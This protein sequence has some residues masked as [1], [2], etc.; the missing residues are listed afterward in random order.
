MGG[1]ALFQRS[2]GEDC[3][4][5]KFKILHQDFE[6]REFPRLRH[7]G[8]CGHWSKWRWRWFGRKRRRL[9]TLRRQRQTGR[10][11]ST[12]G[13]N[14]DR[15]NEECTACDKSGLFLMHRPLP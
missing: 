13:V 7:D 1:R 4:E 12:E 8:R 14:E 2:G 6:R 9:W 5:E 11:L 10:H 15:N 3:V